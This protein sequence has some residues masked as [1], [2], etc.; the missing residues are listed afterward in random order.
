METPNLTVMTLNVYFG[1]EFGALFAASG[2]P[3]FITAV[4][5]L[6][7]QAEAS[8]IPVRSRGIAREIAAAKPDL[9]AL[10]E[11]VQWSTGAPDAMAVKYDF[12]AL[13]LEALRA[14]GVFY[15]PVAISRSL[16]QMVPLDTNGNFLRFKDR[17]AVLLR[18]DPSRPPVLPYDIQIGTFSE[19]FQI[20]NPLTGSLPLPRSWI[21][22]DSTLG[23]TKFRFVTSHIESIDQSIQLAQAR[24]LITTLA[25]AG[26]RA[27]LPVIVAGDF[28]SNAN[29]QPDIEDYT[30]TYPELVGAGFTD[31]W[32][33][34]NPGDPGNTC[35]HA[36]D[37]RNTL[38]ALDRR[39]DLMLTRGAVTPIDA[40]LIAA[41]PAF[42][43]SAGIWSTDHA[44]IFATLRLA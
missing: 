20:K 39:I 7:R 11:V 27:G 22:V 44:G 38:P 32:S 2:L 5:E 12:L 8:E 30:E 41:D 16:D 37:L 25:D 1:C 24:E 18:I 10:Q 15:T 40:R 9:V 33:T 13:I 42:R 34:V 26:L 21:A 4:S 6:W 19:L 28:N 29:R 36:A 23:E 31:V 35:C 3:E 14:E 43:A 17:D